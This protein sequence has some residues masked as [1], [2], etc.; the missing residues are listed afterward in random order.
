MNNAYVPYGTYWS[1]PFA[2]WQGSLGHLHSMKLAANVARDTLAAKKFPIEMID[3]GILG[4]TIPQPSSFFGL[5]WVTGMIGIPDVAGPTVSQACATGA[6][7]LQMAADEVEQGSATCA[8]VVTADRCSNGATLVYP[9]PTGPGATNVT[10]AWVLDNFN[11]DP[12]AMNAMIDTAENVA[13]RYQV[14]TA[15]QHAVVLRRYEQ[16][17]D[18]LANDR[19]FQRRY[20]VEVPITDANFRKQTGALAADE[21]VFGITAGGLAKLKPVKPNGTVTFGSQTHPADGNACM[22]VTTKERAGELAQDKSIEVQF[23]G[24]G[25]ARVEKGYMPMAPVPAARAA[26]EAAA[27]TID[28]IDAVKTHNP[29][30]VNDIVFARD[31]GFPIDKMNNYG[32]SL[33]FGHPQGPTGMRCVI[34]LIE[35]LALRGGGNGLFT[36]CAA[37]D[38]GMAA[39]IKVS[40]ARKH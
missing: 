4:M 5:P 40:D 35:E 3:F 27:L 31:T 30:A 22:I 34:E 7:V 38:T 1:T 14:T 36:G 16:Y 28:D 21:G 13:M 19:A 10:E 9:N 33:I 11:N 12:F 6:R 32:S 24:F 37:G 39:V 26:L 18:A 25:Q 8:L 29:F 2:K 15:E 20:M 17:Q 23:L